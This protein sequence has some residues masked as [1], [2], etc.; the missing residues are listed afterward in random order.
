VAMNE[1]LSAGGDG[2]TVFTSGT[3]LIDAGLDTDA[4]V[5]YIGRHSPV[6]AVTPTRIRRVR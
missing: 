1:F 2:F 6:E 5:A 3:N 4:L